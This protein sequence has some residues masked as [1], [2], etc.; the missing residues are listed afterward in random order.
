MWKLAFSILLLSHSALTDVI[1]LTSLE[2]PPYS[3]KYLPEGGISIKIAK[4]AFLAEG[5]TLH[6]DFYPWARTVKAGLESN[7]Y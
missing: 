7:H 6:V 5:Y 1:R 2:W 3:G 4:E